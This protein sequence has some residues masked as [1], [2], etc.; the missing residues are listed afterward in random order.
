[1][2][3]RCQNFRAIPA[4]MK[5]TPLEIKGRIWTQFYYW[6]KKVKNGYLEGF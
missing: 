2:T 6:V 4:R 1:M 3:T 5:N